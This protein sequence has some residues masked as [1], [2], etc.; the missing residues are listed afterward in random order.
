MSLLN[1]NFNC[2]SVMKK[3]SI[4]CGQNTDFMIRQ[5]IIQ[6]WCWLQITYVI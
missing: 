5:K 3:E 6:I 2:G 1:I 4:Q